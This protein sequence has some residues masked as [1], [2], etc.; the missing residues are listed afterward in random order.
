MKIEGSVVVI[1]G[2]S[3]GIGR[4]TA[5][6]LA[7]RGAI[8]VLTSRDREAL[9][10]VARECGGETLVVAADVTRESELEA[11]ARRAVDAYGRI[12][13]WI[14]DAAVYLVGR[15]DDVPPE[16]FRRVMETNFFGMIH[17]TRA[18]M[19]YFE[20][21]GKGILVN[22][23]SIAGVAPQPYATAYVASKF[24]V[25]GF[26]SALRM[27]LAAERVRGI[28]VCTVLPA[29]IDTPIFQHAANYSGRATRALD[30]TYDPDDVAKAIA[31]LLEHP[32]AE[33]IVGAAGKVT[34]KQA[35]LSLA[36][37][38]KLTNRYYAI[39][40]FQRR[41]APNTDGNLYRTSGPKSVRGGWKVP[42]NRRKVGI[43]VAAGVLGVGW[44]AM[45]RQ[46]QR[47]GADAG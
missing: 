17:G 27:E 25:R 14:N 35:G 6:A 47:P 3:S 40:Q 46:K 4:A 5:H 36:A 13:A 1:T 30:P 38:E 28:H 22:I 34:A 15:F 19:P 31:N 23:A 21:Q 39:D 45:R 24:A 20:R 26:S 44:L 32:K 18:A 9:N 29:A 42:G 37:H 7:A 2:A 8:V 33:V 43:A 41:P 12:D 10:E 11:V 16:A